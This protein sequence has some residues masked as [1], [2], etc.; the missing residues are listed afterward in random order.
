M[1]P[2]STH[3]WGFRSATYNEH[4]SLNI[5]SNFTHHSRAAYSWSSEFIDIV[6]SCWSSFRA[7]KSLKHCRLTVWCRG[8]VQRAH[9]F[10]RRYKVSAG[11][12][13][14]PENSLHWV[15]S[16]VNPLSLAWRVQLNFNHVRWINFP[17][18]FH[19]F[20]EKLWAKGGNSENLYGIYRFNARLDRMEPRMSMIRD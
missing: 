17:G 15:I 2:N 13:N 4:A 6:R 12:G 8:E 7:Q 9:K 16:N 14:S 11:G 3:F 20:F 5:D 1:F 19:K 18:N 10:A